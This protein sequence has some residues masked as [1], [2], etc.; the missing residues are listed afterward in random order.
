MRVEEVVKGNKENPTHILYTL[1]C[2]TKVQFFRH[3]SGGWLSLHV[4]T[5]LPAVGCLEERASLRAHTPLTF[6]T[7]LLTL[8]M[9]AGQDGEQG[10][11]VKEGR[12]GRT[13]GR[14]GKLLLLLLLLF[15]CF[16]KMHDW[17]SKAEQST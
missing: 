7:F 5:S 2:D 4:I 10:M 8:F 16:L 1:S 11:D 13:R 6:L 15:V 17:A 3:P 12:E 14:E 9:E